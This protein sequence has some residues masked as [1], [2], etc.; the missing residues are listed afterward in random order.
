MRISL[1]HLLRKKPFISGNIPPKQK[2]GIFLVLNYKKFNRK[3]CINKFSY[4]KNI[5]ANYKIILI[6]FNFHVNR[7]KLIF[8]LG[9]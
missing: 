8:M 5:D 2:F 6:F 7:P 9:F 3:F 4:L 1:L